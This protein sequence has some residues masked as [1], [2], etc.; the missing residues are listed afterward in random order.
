MTPAVQVRTPC[1]LHFGMFGFGCPDR[2]QFGG[3][4][5][6]VEP[7]SVEV[8]IAPADGFA[9]HG[10]L[11]DRTRK[12]VELLVDRWELPSFPACEITVRSPRD[13]TGLG[14]GTQLNLAIAAGLR[15]FLGLA[16]TSLEEM[17]ATVRRGARSAVGTYGFQL[18][19]L[20][21]DAG[22]KRGQT[23]GSLARR[24]ALP[25]AWRFV[26]FCRPDECGLAGSNEAMAFE[27]LP[28]VP[29]EVTRELWQ[30]TNDEI[31]PAVGQSDCRMFGEAVFRFGRL[32][33]ECFAAVQRGPFASREIERLVDSI[34][35]FGVPG[36]GQSSWGPTVFAVA[37][38]DEQAR[39]LVD[40][41]QSRHAGVE[42]EIVV[43]RPNN[44]GATVEG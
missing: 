36:V 41:V 37:D 3:V 8:E 2:A 1:R 28:P 21:V 14:V 7:P 17:S 15:R 39:Q 10:A 24:V 23:L 22:K 44:R 25:D 33:G 34:R 35:E 18:G 31:L 26:L 20:I 13:H 16:E 6:M 29:Q 9:L 38:G 12:I 4:G 27:R 19:G 32:A 40:W 5:A 11:T 42:Y 43:A 30:I